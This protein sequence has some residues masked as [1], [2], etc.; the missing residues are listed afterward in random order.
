MNQRERALPSGNKQ[1]LSFPAEML[2]EIEDEATRLDR[3]V[4]WV[5]QNAW[6]LARDEIKKLEPA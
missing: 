2:R 5:V 4:S 6:K 1:C 3:S